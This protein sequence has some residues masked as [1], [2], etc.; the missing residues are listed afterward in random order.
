MSELN[1]DQQKAYNLIKEGKNVF[2]TGEAG[3]GKSFVITKIKNDFKDKFVHTA[4]TGIAALNIGGQTIHSLLH[5]RGEAE[6]FHVR[7]LVIDALKRYNTL[8]GVNA[9]IIDEISMMDADTFNFIEYVLRKVKANGQGEEK[10]FGGIQI[11]LVGDLYQL[12]P[13][14]PINHNTDHSHFIFSGAYFRGNFEFIDL[15]EQV[16]QQNAPENVISLLRA[17]RKGKTL[18]HDQLELL[19][20]HSVKQ[21]PDDNILRLFAT[22]ESADELNSKKNRPENCNYEFETFKAEDDLASEHSDND[23]WISEEELNIANHQNFSFEQVCKSY[24]DKLRVPESIDLRIGSRVILLKNIDVENGFANGRIGTVVRFNDSGIIVKFDSYGAFSEAEREIRREDFT[25]VSR[26]RKI[27]VRRQ[28]P[29]ALAWAITI[30]KSQGMTLEKAYID[31]TN[32]FALGQSYVAL[33]RLRNLDGL[34]IEGVD[35]NSFTQDP[36]NL[37]DEINKFYDANL[38]NDSEV[39]FTEMRRKIMEY[40]LLYECSVIANPEAI[41]GIRDLYASDNSAFSNKLLNKIE[42]IGNH[43]DLQL[44]FNDFNQ[45]NARKTRR[46]IKN[47]LKY[48]FLRSDYLKLLNYIEEATFGT[49]NNI[50]TYRE[51]NDITQFISNT[52]R[53]NAKQNN[54]GFAYYLRVINRL[55]LTFENFVLQHREDF[56]PE[57]RLLAEQR[58]NLTPVMIDTIRQNWSNHYWILATTPGNILYYAIRIVNGP[59]FGNTFNVL[60]KENYIKQMLYNAILYRQGRIH[61]W[62]NF[63]YNDNPELYYRNGYNR[64]GEQI[65]GGN[66]INDIYN[67]LQHNHHA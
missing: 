65:I 50:E 13:V 37:R 17:C 56:E 15:Q 45:N 63:N 67:T 11:V 23:D 39:D 25:V 47:K 26:Q 57:I 46:D 32:A 54:Q 4:T 19:E 48:Y 55:D 12:P 7:K 36:T 33:S 30:H 16:R 42:G 61:N 6:N 49:F 5:F 10:P 20:E 3:T 28:Y 41:T 18:T 58:T 52:V 34:Y 44:R 38:N 27:A 8:D 64:F 59:E 53:G 9:I 21:E 43:E 29:L 60:A 62:F 22:N 2:L 35:I 51:T 24:L 40:D 14:A 1:N 66:T 31:L